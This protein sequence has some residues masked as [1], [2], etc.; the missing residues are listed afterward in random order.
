MLTEGLAVGD[1]VF[2]NE[3]YKYLVIKALPKEIVLEQAPQTSTYKWFIFVRNRRGE[4][5]D[6]EDEGIHL[7]EI[8]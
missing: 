5:R 3:G 2:D 6:R 4:W 1:E 8:L 7:V